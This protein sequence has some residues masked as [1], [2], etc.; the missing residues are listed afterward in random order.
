[1]QSHMRPETMGNLG[2]TSGFGHLASSSFVCSRA[3]RRLAAS[4]TT[5]RGKATG[6][7]VP[8]VAT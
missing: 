8:V 4:E 5:V 2:K 1:M 7:V 6:V 3:C